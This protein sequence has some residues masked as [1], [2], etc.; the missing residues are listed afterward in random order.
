MNIRDCA[1]SGSCPIKMMPFGMASIW[2]SVHLGWCPF[3]IVSIRYGAHLGWCPFGI[4]HI[5]DDVH[6]GLCSF[7]I[8]SIQDRVQ[9]WFFTFIRLPNPY[10]ILHDFVEPQFFH[11][12]TYKYIA[13]SMCFLL[14][15]SGD[16]L[17]NSRLY[18]RNSNTQV[19]FTCK[20]VS[21]FCFDFHQSRKR[22][23]A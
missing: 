22:T 17:R 20:P 14:F 16:H 4:T 23:L 13:V 9:Q 10:V 1:H 5:R 6:L 7:G 21:L 15:F 19:I 18:F 12:N 2:D 3:G 11:H 8:P